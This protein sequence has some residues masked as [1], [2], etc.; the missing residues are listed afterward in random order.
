MGISCSRV[1]DYC[2]PDNQVQEIMTVNVPAIE[3]DEIRPEIE[4]AVNASSTSSSSREDTLRQNFF[5]HQAQQVEEDTPMLV[6]RGKI[7]KVY[8]TGTSL[9]EYQS[10]LTELN[11]RASPNSFY[12]PQTVLSSLR[13]ESAAVKQLEEGNNHS[14]FLILGVL[15]GCDQTKC[16]AYQEKTSSR[17]SSPNEEQTTSQAQPSN[18]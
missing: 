3:E 8:T 5:S 13:L 10:R 16:D 2:C 15:L 7:Y 11:R 9:N 1:I 4:S 12:F 17:S 6:T 14:A 18:K